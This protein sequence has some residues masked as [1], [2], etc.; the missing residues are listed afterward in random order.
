[1]SNDNKD[2]I[3]PP[4]SDDRG[5]PQANRTVLGI[6]LALL[7]V[8]V[9]LALWALIFNNG[10]SGGSASGAL[11]TPTAVTLP[12][13]GPTVNE[14]PTA[15]PTTAPAVTPTV[16]P[17]GFEACGVDRE[18]S[19]TSTYI[20]DTNTTPLNQRSEPSV[21]GD[22]AGTFAP[23]QSGLSFTGECVVNVADGYTW[24]KINNGS[25]DVWIASTFVSPN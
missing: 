24:W 3:V 1:V 22:L 23:A 19:V 18:P 8:A 21:D 9:L 4:L 11:P 13:P 5:R 12:T 16:L 2:L 14:A 7:G 6:L 20:V 10:G 15:V 25:A 17:T